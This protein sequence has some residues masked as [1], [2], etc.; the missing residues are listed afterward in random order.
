MVLFPSVQEEGERFMHGSHDSETRRA[1][2]GDLSRLG[3]S[4]LGESCD[5]GE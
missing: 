3:E 4:R 2:E 1:D 5:E